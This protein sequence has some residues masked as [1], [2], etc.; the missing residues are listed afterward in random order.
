MR[1]ASS[2]KSKLPTPSAVTPFDMNTLIL[3][4]QVEFISQP[5]LKP[6]QLSSGLITKA[7]EAR[8][9]VQVSVNGVESL[10]HGSIYL[11][12]LWAWP[13]STPDRSL[14]DEAMRNLCREIA[15]S[16]PALCGNHP[17][18]PLELGLQLLQRSGEMPSAQA[19]PILARK[20]CASPFDA[21]IHD[22]VGQALQLSAFQFYDTDTPIPSAD[23]WFP[24]DGA[25]A[26]IRQ[27]LS[28]P[29]SAL[30]AW[31]AVSMQDDLE[32]DVRPKISE[33]GIRCFK[34]KLL[35]K[36]NLV[37]A[38]RTSE[39]FQTVRTWGVIP[40]ISIDTNEGNP[41]ASAVEDFLMQLERLDSAAYAAVEYLEQPTSRNILDQ[42]QDWQAVAKRKPVMLDEGLVSLELLPFAQSQH[43]SGLALKTCKGHSFSLVAAAWARL[44]GLSLALQ[45][46]TNPGYSAI[47]SFLLGAH[48]KTINGVELNSPQYTPAA[49]EPWL[50]EL[51]GVFQPRNGLH[52][53]DV[54]QS[55]GLGASMKSI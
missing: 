10:G 23:A 27:T 36:D 51:N 12:D 48:L 33:R 5:F 28:T 29:V 40:R 7:T 16:L 42:P 26:A 35:G 50:P 22:A 43:W 30:D 1:R 24:K 18:H 21:A 47:H 53:L 44:N 31:W 11:S 41:S 20:V 19:M 55:I 39:V 13:G 34:L 9:Q 52:K 8:V 14:K 45:D 17:A 4:A 32:K 2:I 37:D 49:N 25:V 15:E 46:L 54:T 6:M 3:S 38:T